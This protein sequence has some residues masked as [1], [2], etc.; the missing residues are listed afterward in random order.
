[1]KIS[2]LK[3][4]ASI[5]SLGREGYAHFGVNKGGAM[6]E[7]S[8]KLGNAL[9]ANPQDAPAIELAMGSISLKAE[10][11]CTLAITGAEYE[12]YLG[13]LRVHNNWRLRLEAGQSLELVRPISGVYAY[14]CVFG[15]FDIK[16]VLNSYSTNL[17]AGFGGFEGRALK[18]GDILSPKSRL[19]LSAI[20]A[21]GVKERAKIRLVKSSEYELFTDE[22]K[23]ALEEEEFII[24][25]NSDRM[26]YRLSSKTALKL[27]AP[28]SLP[29]HGV[30]S[31]CLQVPD[32]GQ[33]IVLMADAQS[34]GGYAKIAS[35]I[36]ADL[37][38][39]AQIGFAKAVRFELVSLDEAIKA[40]TARQTHIENV[41]RYAS[42]N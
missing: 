21:A 15:G 5:Q 31:G 4:L 10:R 41:R 25:P 9:L 1:M 3:G 38:L 35:V 23:L 7:A 37:G 29:S 11:G 18:V 13:V 28:K 17:K 40:R 36:E 6:D 19:K 39:F 2:S 22:S 27:K 26:G 24:S 12:A 30:L 14:I 33:P 34:T 8:L 32:S 16:K 20:G 42:E